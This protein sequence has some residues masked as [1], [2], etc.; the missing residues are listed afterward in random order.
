MLRSIRRLAIVNRG[1]AAMRCLS[2]VAELRGE[3]GEPIT[4][5]AFYT[6]PDAA[7]WFVREADEAISLGPA[8]F[9]NGADC[10]RSTYTDLD[11]LMTALTAARADAA[12]VGWGFVAESPEFAARCEQAGITFIGPP[13]EVIGVLGDKMRAKR[14][15]ESAGIPVVPWSG[16]AVHDA[17][18]AQIAADLLGYPVLVKAAAGG[19]G[20][21]IRSV[22]SAAD[23]AVAFPAAQAEARQAFGDPTVFIERKLEAARHVEVQVVADGYGTVWAAGIR[24]CSIQ[25]RNRKVIEE[26]GC[27][28]LGRPAE[29]ELR[30]AATRL[31]RAAGYRS[32]GTVEFLVDS[33][34]RQFMFMEANTRLQV[35][36]PVTEMTTGLDLVK[37]QLHIARGGRLPGRPPPVRGYAIEAR[38]NAEDAEHAFAPAPGRVSA[39]RLPTGPGIRVDTGVAEGDQVAPEF[40]SMI[41]KIVA[42]GQDRDQALRR[43]RRGL[44]QSMAVI[45]GGT[46]N[47]AFLLAL[48]D[49]PEVQ[50]GT[51]DNR[52]LDRLTARQ[53]HLPPPHPVAL[54]AAAVEA[55]VADQAAVQANFF[56]AA[57]RGRPE[58]PDTVGHQIGLRVRGESYRMRVRDLG[59]GDYRIDADEGRIDVNVRRFGRYESAVTCHGRRYRVVADTQGPRLLVEV[60]GLPHVISRDDGGL[61]RSPAPA[62]VVAVLTSPGDM[63]R[64]GDPLVVVEAM[65]M[66][67]TITAPYPG[68]VRA[69]LAEVNT[70]VEAGA[71]LVRLQPPEQA[72]ADS[73]GPRVDLASLAWPCSATDCLD[74]AHTDASLRAYLLGYD[75]SG[76][77]VRELGHHRAALL[78]DLPSD[79]IGVIGTEQ[80][81][82]E[83]FAD[84]AGLSRRVH[85]E[86][87]DEHSRSSQEYLYTYL[88]VLD[89]DRSG[90]P[91]A[92][93]RRLLAA[94]T[95][96]GVHSLRRAP[97][98]E[99]ALL[100]MY[101]AVG[102]LPMAAPV[103]IA[104]LDRWR[105]EPSALAAAVAPDGRLPV[106]DQLIAAAQGRHPE[107]CDLAREVRF[108]L[109]DAPLLQAAR[110]SQYAEI[111]GCLSELAR[112]PS[113]RRTSG[114]IS[115]LVSFPIPMRA[116]LRDAYR[117]AD[118]VTR[119]RL[120]EARTRQYYRIRELTG[121]RCEMLGRHLTC[122]ADY[123]EDGAPG[124]TVHL[125]SAYLPLAELP[126]F[127][128]EL[129][130]YLSGLPPAHRVVVDI[131]SWRSEPFIADEQMAGELAVMLAR[132]QFGRDLGRL[133][134][135]V[136]S[137]S[138]AERAEEHLRTQHFCYRQDGPAYTEDPLFRNMHPMLAE[139]LELWRLSNFLLQRLPSAEDVYLFHAV[140]HTNPKDE[141]L[142]ALAEV[143]DLTPARDSGGQVIGYPHMEGMLTQALADIH[144]A[145]DERP[146]RQ[147]PLSNRVILYVRPVWDIP[148]ATWRMLAH[149]LAPLAAGLG[150][151]KVA[152]RVHTED[153]ATGERRDAILDVENL[154]DRGVT[155]RVRPPG[156]RPIQ[157]LTEYR[158]KVLRSHR[159]GVPYPYELIRMLTPPVG[160][161]A[162]FPAGEFTEYDFPDEGD[163]GRLGPV[164]RPYGHNRAGVVVGVISN[165]TGLVPEGMRR[166]A[167][168]GD[169]TSGLGNLAEPECRRILAAIDL[170]E[171]LAV[172]VEWFAVSSGARIALD[173][174]TENMDWIAAV[175][176]RLVE[177]TQAGG[178]VN[179]VVTG[180]NVGAQPYWNAEA[181][182]LMHTRGIL[183][184]T[185]VS[186]MVL[187]GKSS[188]DYS[189][190][191]SA[192]DNWGIGGF[193]QVMGP[194]GE[195]QYWAP[196]LAD[197]CAVLLRHYSHSYVVPGERYPR[198]APTGDASDRDVCLSPHKPVPGSD[199][200]TVGDVF[201]AELNGD[202]KKP[203]DMR[204]VMQ[205]VADSDD[206]PFER[207]ARWEDAEMAIVWE[208]R[209]GGFP[210]CLIGL[211]SQALSRAGFLPA[212]GPPSWTSGT[213]FPQSSRKLARAINA[214]SGNR[215]V[216]V[217]ANLTGFDGSPESMRKWQLE[218]GAEIGRAVTNF[219]GPIVFVVVSRYHGGA[220]VV[221]SKRLHDQMDT[222]AVAGSFASVIGGAPAA[223]VVLS[224]EVTAR[225]EQDPRVVSQRERIAAATGKALADAHHDLARITQAVR[226]EKLRE[227]ADE[228]DDIH[229]IK[230]ALRVGSVD[231]II[232]PAELRPFIIEALERRLAGGR[233]VS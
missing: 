68:T 163:G 65:K 27:T 190:G 159:F 22:E 192:E 95:R 227:V 200:T 111:E 84:V 76:D 184:M 88:A 61:V 172:P 37:L 221:F 97:E 149:R 143:R 147:R 140:A 125:A 127:A 93:R 53:A 211:E 150:L 156:Q 188:L 130:E 67:T 17:A 179:V 193:E 113:G 66:E 213:L 56:A 189:G 82:L 83:I 13:S 63:V 29:A 18:S 232:A 185:P 175:L 10:R 104:I 42:W 121:L 230:R 55:A 206:D 161:P 152:V 171:R 120:L 151:E 73:G 181:T 117:A 226:A 216:V 28:G 217:L 131:E 165:F 148:A 137:E 204:S 75:L 233:P 85:E 52:W 103:V 194:N 16:G 144:R 91:E 177:F 20:R 118:D 57:A 34:A 89:P 24:D 119:A 123:A 168:L 203:F 87:A 182:M 94:L 79:D 215:P 166:V 51:Y 33:T 98:L 7:S 1:E 115:R 90:T 32:V 6:D 50:A 39:L 106:L 128:G 19:G 71:P 136:T 142:I 145:L 154:E 222:A 220:F 173:S 99:R 4:A 112:S 180:I 15:A 229:D 158:Q 59:H 69:V 100:R 205:A 124:G 81:L 60:D 208:A 132:T 122:L 191:V 78:A 38:L 30:E 187:T 62:F 129:G 5:I 170:A 135:T 96:Y 183:V 47:K 141:R 92:F 196:T 219:R 36:H 40:D 108:N 228:F 12:W 197:A 174:G 199:F 164:D 2:A 8:T 224:R 41:A 9:V 218:Y 178:E 43:L 48:V 21:G 126:A 134:I 70:R 153:T 110:A 214:A 202:R 102:R 77:D 209:I 64:V 169:P 31:C 225:T 201:S 146:V 86:A 139:R 155:V 25:R 107:V 44:A 223:A 231:H 46:T 210:V 54:A 49:Q 58:L 14:L 167:I 72:E 212:D 176:R 26:S 80:E 114:L 109:V 207:W 138:G 3:W 116:R 198:R 45:D 11:R 101:R 160:A 133:D 195:A 162:D 157:P 105:R 23:L 35:E 74:L 186:A